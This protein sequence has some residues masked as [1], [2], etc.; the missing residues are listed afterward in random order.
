MIMV[1]GFYWHGEFYKIGA[2]P[3]VLVGGLVTFVVLKSI[4]WANKELHYRNVKSSGSLLFKAKEIEEILYTDE[5]RIVRPL[6][7]G[8]M[9]TNAIYEAK[10]H[11][12]GK[13]HGRLLITDIRRKRFV[14]LTPKDLALNLKKFDKIKSNLQ[15]RYKL[16]SND[17]IV[18]VITF[19]PVGRGKA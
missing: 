16:D 3:L 17:E 12:V 8:R 14:D 5:S 4:S 6:R 11:V 10:T 9:K 2:L 1:I 18:R 15:K 19:K 7:V 13:S